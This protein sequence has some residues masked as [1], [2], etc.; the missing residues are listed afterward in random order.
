M[1][2]RK[3]LSFRWMAIVIG[4]V[5]L[6][7]PAAFAQSATAQAVTG[8]DT[9]DFSLNVELTVENGTVTGLTVYNDL[10]E[11][12]MTN[13]DLTATTPEEALSAALTQIGGTGYF[14]ATDG[15]PYLLITTTGGI[16]NGEVAKSLRQTAGDFFKSLGANVVV[17]NTAIGADVSAKAAT[18]GLPGGRYLM[19]EYIAGQQ[20]ISV[21]EAIALYGKERVRDLMRSFEGLRQAMAENDG[22][23]AD[24]NVEGKA[25]AEG[26]AND[27]ASGEV[28]KTQEQLQLEAQ[29]REQAKE[30]KQ[31]EQ[32]TKKDQQQGENNPSK[33]GGKK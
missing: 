14:S 31:Q 15:E 16:L 17:D 8:A 24:E 10:G 7:T 13:T 2:N 12:L 4:M 11:A 5:M 27:E 25:N 18:L 1:K 28:E 9:P 20:G 22:E 19:M 30:Q 21:E 29:E 6:F 33:G 32:Q 23:I 3:N 26:E